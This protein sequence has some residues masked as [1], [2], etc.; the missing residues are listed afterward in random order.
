[1]EHFSIFDRDA[2][3]TTG[4]LV[5]KTMATVAMIPGADMS[6]L[7]A[8]VAVLVGEGAPYHS[9]IDTPHD[10]MRNTGV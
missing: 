2:V 5:K 7:N 6:A 9:A 4:G 1:M 8:S 10:A 3:A